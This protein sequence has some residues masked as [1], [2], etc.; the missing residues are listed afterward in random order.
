LRTDIKD[1]P[2]YEA[3]FRLH[4][5]PFSATPDTACVFDTESR[6]RTMRRLVE[7]VESEQGIGVL[8]GPGGI[9]KSLAIAG[10]MELFRERFTVVKT[11]AAGLS[12]VRSLLQ[13]L[14]YEL[15]ERYTGLDENECRLELKACLKRLV[16]SQRPVVL[17]VDEGEQL[18]AP[19]FHELRNLV[20]EVEH[21]RRLI[22]LIV[23]GHPALEDQLLDPSV[24]AFYQRIAVQEYLA[25]LTQDE[26]VAYVLFRL[27]RAGALDDSLIAREAL[28]LIAQ[29][30]DGL[31][32][33]LNQLCD[34]ALLLAFVVEVPQVTRRHVEEALTD[35]KQLPLHW[36][37]NVASNATPSLGEVSS[38]SE[39]APAPLT[40]A[41]AFEFGADEPAPEAEAFDHVPGEVTVSAEQVL[42]ASSSGEL[43][44]NLPA[45]VFTGTP[46]SP[47]FQG[48]T[49]TTNVTAADLQPAREVDAE[50]AARLD[51]FTEQ[52][53]TM[54]TS[55]HGQ[56]PVSEEWSLPATT[57]ITES[58]PELDPEGL[59]LEEPRRHRPLEVSAPEAY[60]LE[61]VY[62]AWTERAGDA[63]Q[64]FDVVEALPESMALPAVSS[65]E[66]DTDSP[67]V[68]SFDSDVN[69]TSTSRP[70]A[71]FTARNVDRQFAER[72]PIFDRYAAL[73]AGRTDLPASEPE[74]AVERRTVEHRTSGRTGRGRGVARP[75]ITV[76][77]I[78]SLVSQADSE[79]W[80][81]AEQELESV[82]KS[83]A[84]ETAAAAYSF[85]SPSESA[86]RESDGIE[87]DDSLEEHVLRT[88]E[89]LLAEVNRRPAAPIRETPT[90]FPSRAPLTESQDLGDDEEIE[91]DVVES[92]AVDSAA[93]TVTASPVMPPMERKPLFAGK[94]PATVPAPGVSAT[95]G[96]APRSQPRS[97]VPAER[98]SSGAYGLAAEPSA[99]SQVESAAEAESAEDHGTAI[100]PSKYK[101]LFSMLRRKLRRSA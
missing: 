61:P 77:H 71:T 59:S 69:S 2:M 26:S 40:N 3:Y 66:L 48:V 24:S 101:R 14:L 58:I 90:P 56:F 37:N 87:S 11:S 99:S 23:A 46:T 12:S 93:E 44:A 19:L 9:G 67:A 68:L 22:R 75:D 32:R 64:A 45:A 36:N 98:W 76:D 34:H 86:S 31:P 74:P 39:A 18:P 82:V 16:Q 5:R 92:V 49:V 65:L 15:G 43:V 51:A 78:L 94:G 52:A 84:T 73:D 29:T 10:L 25:P 96:A 63:V 30:S 53:P 6:S 57:S 54:M 4:R 100:P 50:I 97:R 28:Q 85:G 79:E 70:E 80:S 88:T 60:E 62:D 42:A 17:L 1:E 20:E 33:C 35:L 8:I 21:G 81:E 41:V 72:E 83:R 55:A 7:L 38:D 91:Y 89:E 47:E 95:S 13:G 27:R